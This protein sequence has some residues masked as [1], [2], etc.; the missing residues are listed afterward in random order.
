LLPISYFALRPTTAA[1]VDFYSTATS[2][3][4][5]TVSDRRHGRE[6]CVGNNRRHTRTSKWRLRT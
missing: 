4:C 5:D 3:F 1:R 6:T 2:Q